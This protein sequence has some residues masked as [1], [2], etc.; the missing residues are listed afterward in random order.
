MIDRDAERSWL[1]SQLT[2]GSRQLLVVYGRRRVGKT[3]L[4]TEVL[5]GLSIPSVYHLC[6]QRGPTHNARVFAER[7]ADT[8]DDV[9][10]VVDDFVDAFRYLARRA[11]GPFVVALDEFSYLVE[12]DE[13]VPSVFQTIVDE[14]LDGTDISLVLLGSSISMMEEGVLSY[15]SPLYGRRTGQWR[16]EPLAI[17]GVSEFF[18]NYDPT[19]IISTYSVVGG[20][21]AYLEQFDPEQSLL[22]NVERNVLRKGSFLYEEPEFLLSQELR[23]PTTYMAVLEAVAAGATRVSE[24]ANEIGRDASSLSRYL[25]NLSELALVERETPVTDPDGRGMYRLSD[26]F[27]RF[28]FR[29]VAP[30]R[31]TLEQGHTESVRASIAETLPTHVSWTFE[32]VCRQ[33]VSRPSFP[34]SCSRVGRWWYGEDEIDVVGIDEQTEKLLLGECKWTNTP[35]AETLLDELKALEPK[36]RW[37]GSQRD[38]TYTLFSK[39]GFTS[40]MERLEADRDDLQLFTVDD[41]VGLFDQNV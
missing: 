27:L 37:H 25:Q 32:D 24:I 31:S 21:P 33:S 1:R 26:Q 30:N 35:V 7:C 12:E 4:V 39:A 10:P 6:D 41:V 9:T 15:E 8:F 29:Y 36:V 40:E 11:D 13:T 14:T 18:P 19:A 23:E 20:I 38:V 34:V 22:E 28:W 2:D 3:T 16:L 17:D 5:D